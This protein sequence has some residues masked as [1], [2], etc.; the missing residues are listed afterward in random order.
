MPTSTISVPPNEQPSVLPP[1][2]SRN[3]QQPSDPQSL[4]SSQHQEP[5]DASASTSSPSVAHDQ[6][7]SLSSMPSC[8]PS[9]VLDPPNGAQSGVPESMPPAHTAASDSWRPMESSISHLVALIP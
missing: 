6:Q 9:V 8:Q 1:L 2:F 3:H 4:P 5:R 7:V